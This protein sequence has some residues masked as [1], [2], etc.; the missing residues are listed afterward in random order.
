VGM[1]KAPRSS[2]TQGNH[3][4]AA[5]STPHRMDKI[6]RIV[7]SLEDTWH[8]G[9]QV[10]DVFSPST[11]GKS[12][13]ETVI[14][15]IRYLFFNDES[16]LQNSLASFYRQAPMTYPNELLN[17]LLELLPRN[18][19]RTPQRSMREAPTRTPSTVPPR[20]FDLKLRKFTDEIK[21][22]SER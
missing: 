5:P 10:R 8:L 15:R 14:A 16:A 1:R 13:A 7:H 17:L 3:D 20:S 19:A 6:N 18:P 22:C 4:Q 9:L 21:L 2:P 12:D 11:K